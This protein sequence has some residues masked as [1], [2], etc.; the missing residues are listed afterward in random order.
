[1]FSKKKYV[2]TFISSRVTTLYIL[3]ISIE[4]EKMTS[5]FPYHIK[6]AAIVQTMI[7][8][9]LLEILIYF[10]WKYYSIQGSLA[11]I[12]SFEI[13]LLPL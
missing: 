3:S 10:F 8:G 5:S 1:M 12:K 7:T 9:E 13:T 11:Y 4:K 2:K 6:G